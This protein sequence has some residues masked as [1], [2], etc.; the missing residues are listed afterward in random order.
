MII[1]DQVNEVQVNCDPK[2][3]KLY[4]Q[5]RLSEINTNTTEHFTL[6]SD[7]EEEISVLQRPP[8][9]HLL[10]GTRINLE[11]VS[12]KEPEVEVCV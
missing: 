8:G 3:H 6:Q 9:I 2:S 12:P 1:S 11:C 4:N 7:D 10:K 5:G